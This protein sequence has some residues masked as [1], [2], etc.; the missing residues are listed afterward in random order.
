MVGTNEHS[1]K[2][3][4]PVVQ[5]VWQYAPLNAGSLVP[6]GASNLAVRQLKN[7]VNR[8]LEGLEILRIDIY[9]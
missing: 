1:L 2:V 9:N 3:N 6:T 4:D 5:S 7:I 8:K